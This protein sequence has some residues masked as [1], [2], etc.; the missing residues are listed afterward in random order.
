MGNM[1]V[2][3]DPGGEGACASLMVGDMLDV[4]PMPWFPLV[5]LDAKGLIEWLP[6]EKACRHVYVEEMSVRPGQGVSGVRTSATNWGRIVGILEGLR[7]PFTVVRPQT[8]RK[9]MDCGI[10]S[11]GA[12]AE[13]T[14]LLK[15]KSVARAQQIWPHYDFRRTAKCRKAHDGMAEAALIAEYGRRIG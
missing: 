12:P 14:K 11:G 13:R 8:W 6:D 7:L 2:G 5:G 15:A 1:V 3:I 9:A 4:I 10:P